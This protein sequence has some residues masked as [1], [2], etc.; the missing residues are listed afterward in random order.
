MEKWVKRLTTSWRSEKPS[1]KKEVKQVL[2]K[3]IKPRQVGR[4]GGLMLPKSPDGRES[5]E[6]GGAGI[7]AS[8]GGLEG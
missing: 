8:L 3:W 4:L 5:A 1:W 6:C 2:I 7:S